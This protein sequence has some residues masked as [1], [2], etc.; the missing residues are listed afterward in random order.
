MFCGCFASPPLPGLWDA[1]FALPKY[2]EAPGMESPKEGK[3]KGVFTVS[4]TAVGIHKLA[5]SPGCGIGGVPNMQ[6]HT[7]ELP[8]V[9][10]LGRLPN[11]FIV[12]PPNDIGKTLYKVVMD[13]VNIRN[14]VAGDA[15]QPIKA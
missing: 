5:V 4:I 8:Q 12:T 6:T 10:K 13:S 7:G 11:G 2:A 3:Q 1:L 9:S 14:I 15:P